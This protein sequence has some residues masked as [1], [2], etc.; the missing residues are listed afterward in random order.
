D[1]NSSALDTDSRYSLYIKNDTLITE[2]SASINVQS[3]GSISSGVYI[4][5]QS[6][7]DSTIRVDLSG[8]LSSSLSGAPALSIFSS[9]GNDSTIILN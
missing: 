2:Q 3:N 7:D 5:N 1:T 8:I 9:A 4:D 6:S